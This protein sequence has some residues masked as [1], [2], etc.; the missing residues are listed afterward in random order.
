MFMGGQASG[1]GQ[2]GQA[3]V[4]DASGCINTVS[5]ASM[6]CP[7]KKRCGNFGW[8]GSYEHN[9]SRHSTKVF[10]LVLMTFIQ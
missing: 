8:S 10:A 3:G 6:I 7:S 2:G 1:D 5:P 4:F 9:F